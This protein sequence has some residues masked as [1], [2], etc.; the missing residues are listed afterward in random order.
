MKE[1][2]KKIFSISIVATLLSLIS[3]VSA[4]AETLDSNAVAKIGNN[5]Y[6]TLD[7]AIDAL[8]N[9]EAIE[10]VSNA[11][12][13][14]G[15]I[16][17]DKIVTIKGN[18]Y[19][20][21][22][23]S[24][25][26]TEDGRLNL[27]GTI[28]FYNTIVYFGNT[29]NWSVVMGYES[30]LNLY[31][32]SK[33]SFEYN[34]IYTS[35]NATINVDN[36]TFALTNMK[37]TSMMAEAYST[38]N[39][40]NNSN[41]TISST[42]DINGVTGFNI[43]VDNSKLAISDCKNQGI[44]KGS[45]I[46]TNKA[47]ALLE[48]CTT[49]INLYK[50]NNIVV[51]EGTTLEIVGSSERAI[52][53]Q[54]SKGID[55]SL[56]VK[57]GGTLNVTKTGSYWLSLKNIDDSKYYAQQGSIT[58][59]VYGY[60]DNADK[61]YLYNNNSIN[62]EDGAIVNIKNNYVRGIT[63]NGTNAYIGN[64]TVITDNGK[65]LVAT[66]GGIYNIRGT[67]TIAKGAKIYNN[68]AYAQ[69]D[70]I[71][72]DTHGILS[73]QSVS[74][75]WYLNGSYGDCTDLI[76]GWYFDTNVNRWKA[77]GEDTYIEP[78]E[79]SKYEGVIA[80]KAA[81]NLK[82]EVITD[83]VD[84][85]NNKLADSN[86]SWGYV[87]DNYKTESK[88][89]EGYKLIK[90]IGEQ[91]GS[92]SKDPIKVIYVY[93]HITS[94]VVIKYVDEDFKEISNSDTITGNVG[95]DYET[96]AKDIKGYEL[97]EVLGEEKG[98][99]EKNIIK[100]VTYVY[101]HIFGVG[102]TDDQIDLI[103]PKT[104]IN[105][106]SFKS[107]NNKIDNT[108]ATN[109]KD[110][111]VL[112][113]LIMI[114]SVLILKPII[115]GGYM[116]KN[117]KN[118]LVIIVFVAGMFLV[119]T[120]NVKAL[121]TVAKINDK[122]YS[123]LA[124]AIKD[125]QEN[126]TVVLLSDVTE[127]IKITKAVTL[128]LNNHTIKT[129]NNSEVIAVSVDNASK[130]SVVTVKNGTVMG[131]DTNTGTGVYVSGARDV[132]KNAIKVLLSDL[133]VTKNNAINGAGVSI[134]S[135]DIVISNCTI[136]DNI[137]SN[138][139]GGM[140]TSTMGQES[141]TV[142]IENSK[143]L[144]NKAASGGGIAMGA[145]NYLY[146]GSTAT[147]TIV[148]SKISDNTASPK[149]DNYGGGG[150]Y[151]VGNGSR[152]IM[153]SGEISN[154]TVTKGNGGGIYSMNWRGITVKEGN[155]VNNKATNLGGGIYIKNVNIKS[156][157]L[158][159]EKLQ[160]GSEVV[161]T[162]NS[163]L[164]GAGIALENGVTAVIPTGVSLYNNAATIASDDLYSNGVNGNIIKLG[165]AKSDK[166][167][168][169]CNDVING[170]YQDGEGNRWVAHPDSLNKANVINVSSGEYVGELNI[171]AAHNLKGE[172]I[173]DYVDE[174]N[175]KLADSNHSW[176]YVGDNYKTESKEIEGYKLIKIIGEQEGSYSEDPI[177]VAYVYKHITSSVVIKYVDEDFKEI[178]SSD[179]ITGNVGSDYETVAKDI[180][181]YE[182]V[183]VLGEEKG[184]YEKNIIKTVTYVYKHI[185]GVGE[186]DK[187]IDLIPPKTGVVEEN[188]SFNKNIFK[189]SVM[190]FTMTILNLK[191][192]RIKKKQL[193]Q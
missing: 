53:S 141:I 149:Y 182:L 52:M 128:D 41:F 93:K 72:N 22:V 176:G 59:G 151:L 113:I 192:K 94:S 57:N 124:E 173:T 114:F 170:W 99:Y 64:T 148:N 127:N 23:P 142:R 137:A 80:I 134:N 190:L 159:L 4:N 121:E 152:F 30:Y 178:S 157:S 66:A 130:N 58:M 24:Q 2:I 168:T 129:N 35:P 96:V 37:Y 1:K 62:F 71:Y 31:D 5:Y 90:V 166:L 28:N 174:N 45:L 43:N 186:T 118:M 34:G 56:I 76:N 155:I 67:L 102:E 147:T 161:V 70:D 105:N 104:G 78:V 115:Q 180:K 106:S 156:N 107:I 6:A 120:K 144:N 187:Q 82:G 122:Q 46:L 13:E 158:E 86:H 131:S 143:I 133:Q 171:K 167:L 69:A 68:H 117:L 26:K 84:E 12:L 61:I 81:H 154:N 60:Y 63:F 185:F 183:E 92:Y 48:N 164:K 25:S 47:S 10:L 87:G 184:I 20:I 108:S 18:G 110:N 193:Q 162:G 7:E 17:K 126:D 136:S 109:V 116:K 85:N 27:L 79:P 89:I 160:L 145:S 177:K 42:M 125:S 77:H 189:T 11:K 39:I 95:S 8:D 36:S 101:K 181:G 15:T 103:P 139:G 179:T 175:N 73:L 16:K 111:S 55:A 97:V 32:G 38:I 135:G 146:N 29:T 54:G 9:S 188:L 33:V 119:N 88:E 75:D 132:D 83:Y 153:E 21:D 44:V 138:S 172:V 98:I 169:N 74:N 50:G 112:K 40:R 165:E 51:N 163:S 140:Y 91:E 19:K 14:I 65:D 150:V 3:I 191:I 100:T 123:T 49:G